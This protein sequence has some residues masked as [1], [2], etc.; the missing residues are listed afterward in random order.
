MDWDTPCM[1]TLLVWKGVPQVEKWLLIVIFL[2]YD[3]EK[4]E[5]RSAGKKLVQHQNFFWLQLPQSGID[6]PASW[7]QSSTAA[8]VTPAL[9][10][11]GSNL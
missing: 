8:L 1:L 10:S 2:L 7:G 4:L 3:V 9:P 6:I 11:Y 5:C